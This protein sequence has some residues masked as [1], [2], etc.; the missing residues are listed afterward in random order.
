M[1]K[2]GLW[3]EQNLFL[4]HIRDYRQGYNGLHIPEPKGIALPLPVWNTLYSNIHDIN[5]DV[6]KLA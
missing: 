3:R 5:H 4:I 2:I 6:H 1:V